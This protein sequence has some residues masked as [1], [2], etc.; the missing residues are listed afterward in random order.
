MS[1]ER[2]KEEAAK[3]DQMIQELAQ[4]GEPT[5]D[6]AEAAQPEV[7]E[8][9]DQGVVADA[10]TD[11]Q[12]DVVAL[13]R[14]EA[15]KWEQR[16]RSLDGMIQARDRQIEQLHQLVAAM[17]QAPQQAAPEPEQKGKKRVSKEDEDVFGADLVDLNRRVAKEELEG[18]TSKL[19]QRIAELEQRLTGVAQTTAVSVHERFERSLGEAY[20][21]WKKVDNNPAFIDWLKQSE[22]RFRLF[23]EAV[24]AYDV[25]GTAYFYQEFGQ[26]HPVASTPGVDPRLERQI[27]PGK[28]KS[29]APQAKSQ[30]DKKVWTRT[31]IA[32]TYNEK[33]SYSPEEFLRIER[34]IA[35]AQRDGRVDF[36]R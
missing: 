27:A 30:S 10:A 34:D 19:E 17:Q 16:Y 4:Q 6:Q 26:R 7:V 31:E 13:M 25:A 11:D 29:V 23:G 20:Q 33:K 8:Q 2:I 14:E 18:Y 28:A 35:N 32:R 3:A 5:E 36:S 15:A 9:T 21:D 24:R 22:T 1:I 12:G